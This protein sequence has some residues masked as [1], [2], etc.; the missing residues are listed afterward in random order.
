MF[1]EPKT[2]FEVVPEIGEELGCIDSAIDHHFPH[3]AEKLLFLWGS[4]EC[5]EY[6][7]SL[8][9]GSYEVGRPSR[10]GFPLWALKELLIIQ[11]IH[12]ERFPFIDS[13][14]TRRKKDPW[15]I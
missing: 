8:L 9:D 2:I 4:S 3:I 11:K 7:I 15:S 5:A 1:T 12:D 14:R 6:I 13:T 10:E